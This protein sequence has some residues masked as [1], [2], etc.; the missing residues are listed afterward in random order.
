MSLSELVIQRP[1]PPAVH[2][3]NRRC[4]PGPDEF[5]PDVMVHPVTA[6]NVR[7]TGTPL[8]LIEVLSTNRSDDLVVR[9]GKVRGGG[10]AALQDR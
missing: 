8:L 1:S 2:S 9:T 3:L 6:E 5:I 4:W 7:F 10:C